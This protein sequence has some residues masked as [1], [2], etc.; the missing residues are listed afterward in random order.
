MLTAIGLYD[1]TLRRTGE[2]DDIAT[3]LDLS[4]EFEATEAAITQ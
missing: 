4:A 2:I 1:H 3:D